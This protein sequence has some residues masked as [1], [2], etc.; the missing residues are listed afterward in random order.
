MAHVQ[1][2]C[3]YSVHF[4]RFCDIT[5]IRNNNVKSPQGKHA[6]MGAVLHIAS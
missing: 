4:A 6:H 2:H 5:K 3:V 1:N